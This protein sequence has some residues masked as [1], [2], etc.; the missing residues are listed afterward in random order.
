MIEA[1]HHSK[2]EISLDAI[3]GIFLLFEYLNLEF[4]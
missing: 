2:H 3:F 1:A 4:S